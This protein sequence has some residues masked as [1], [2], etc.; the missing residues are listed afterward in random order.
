MRLLTLAAIG[1]AAYWFATRDERETGSKPISSD[2]NPRAK[3]APEPRKSGATGKPKEEP[4][5]GRKGASS[6]SKPGGKAD[7][8]TRLKGVGPKLG[9]K[10]SG[11]GIVRFDQIAS[12]SAA[13][14]AQVDADL[15]LRG[16]ITRDQWVD[17]AKLLAA[18]KDAEHKARFG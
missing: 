13:D 14:I 9:E 4:E 3:A 16:R 18:G 2:R 17:Q 5:A 10:L 1:A 6:S 12:W 7:Q 8:L 11:I 15:E